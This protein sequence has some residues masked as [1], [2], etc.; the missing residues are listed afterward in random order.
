MADRTPMTED[1]LVSILRKEEQGSQ[2]WQD[3]DL[4]PIREEALDY[5]NRSPYGDEQEGQS[6][7]VTSE[8]QDA[9][10][11][12]MPGLMRVFTSSGDLVKFSPGAPGE[13]KWAA[14]A[15]AYIPHV[16]MKQNPGFVIVSALLKDAV[17]YRLS[18][19]CVD[20]E[21]AEETRRVPVQALP[22]EAIDEI[23]AEATK[24]PGTELVMELVPDPLPEPALLPP[25][26][27]AAMPPEQMMGMG[28]Q[29]LLPAPPV[30]TFSGTITVTRKLKRV[31][32]DN[33]APEDIRFTPSA[34]DQDK[35][36][37]LGFVK[38]TT[39]SDLVQ[40]LMDKGKSE[41]EA[42]A[43][44]D[45]MRSERPISPEESQRND[46]AIINEQERNTVGDSE[47]P[48]WVVVAYVRVDVNGDGISE[49]LRVVYGHAGGSIGTIIDQ[50]EWEGPASIALGTPILMPHTI[51]GRCLFDQTKDLQQIG[52]VLTRGLLTNLYMVN[53][54][55]PVVSDQVNLD[56]LL[57]WTPGSPIRLK[58]GAKPQDRHVDW[59]QVPSVT[60]NV[61]AALEHQ[62]TVKENRTGVSRYNQGQD[63]D[64]LN[65][66]LGGLN[67]I[68][69]A[70]SQRQDLIAQTF[71]QTVI[72]RLY[73]LI[74]RAVKK[75][76][77][78]PI[79]YHNGKAFA[80]CDPT[81]WPDEM[82]VN[83]NVAGI[84]NQEQTLQQLT[85]IGAAQEKLIA[86]QG[87]KAEG[88]YVFA[89]N[90]ANLSQAL[91]DT[92]GYKQPG[93]FFAPAEQVA[94]TPAATTDATQPVDP[95]L[96]AAQAQIEIMREAAAAEVEI[97]RQK[98]MADVEATREKARADIAIAEFKAR[99]WA[100]IERYKAGLKADLATRNA[101]H[102]AG[103]DALDTLASAHAEASRPPPEP[104][105][106][107]TQ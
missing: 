6:Q 91:A 29:M 78:G 18:G 65:K 70:S 2:S 49:M 52:S 99:Q 46:S 38:R 31:V 74:Y 43:I 101:D 35:A 68:M 7:V 44:V 19:A 67:R 56:S 30:Q 69:S 58:A 27:M 47:R 95:A 4:T 104:N 3:S 33:I 102:Q 1:E 11:S 23:T 92:L 36:S 75:A 60:A 96:L 105:G 14:E 80:N 82:A 9:V 42:L 61:L 87:G 20:L 25:E 57:D 98:A 50:M 66:T 45:D 17:M 41:N 15:S 94:A 107:M 12:L 89:E 21:D 48:L 86:L 64:S 10:E 32:V 79:S 106:S 13:E 51:V 62:A 103:L 24:R 8:F 55:R 72:S 5:Y 90:I 76:A 26:A 28:D 97:K 81:Q 85:V 100:E 59:L 71:A 84:T 34:R 88:P 83:V 39:S 73:M 77:T 16:L 93:F 53:N 40:M 22:Q 63:A 54:P 37:F